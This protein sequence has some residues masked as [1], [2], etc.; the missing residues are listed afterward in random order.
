MPR[1]VKSRRPFPA[2]AVALAAIALAGCGGGGDS[3]GSASGPVL[4]S[5][6]GASVQVPAGVPAPAGSIK[7]GGSCT[8]AYSLTASPVLT[9]ADPLLAQQWH[10][11]NTGQRGGTAGEDLRALDAWATTRGAGVRV[12][13]IDDAV[14]VTHP[15]LRPN[16]VD[17]ASR[18]YRAGNANTTWPLPCGTDDEHGTAV[19]GL[20]LARDDNGSG[21]AG[22]APRA[23]LVAFD[24]LSSG[25]DADVA[26]A[27]TRDG[28]AN[29]IYQ[30][31]WGSPDNG[32]LSPADAPFVAALE[33]GVASGRGGL[34]SVYVFAGGNG[35]C[36]ARASAAGPCLSDDSNYDGYV[37]QRAVITVCA[38]DDAGR[39]PSYG[40]PGA[41]LTVCAPSSGVRQGITTTA[42]QAQTRDDFS[43]TSA[44]TPMVSGVAAL[45]LAANPQLTWRDVRLILAKSARKND[46]SDP[47]WLGPTGGMTFNH[48]YGFGVADAQAAVAMARTWT[49]VGGSSTL[50]RCGPYAGT[51][52]VALPDRVGTTVAERSDAV[53]V[54]GCAITRIE[55]VEVR[56]T[57]QHQYAGDLRVRLA[58]PAG[59]TSRL[60]DARACAGGCGS[61]ANWLF[62]SMRHLDEAPNGTWTL[63]VA[64]D[65]AQDTGTF[66][67]WSLV[68]HG[69]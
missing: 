64:D 17:G 35:G 47:D 65:A 36:Y 32:A 31:S 6:P 46:P 45:M 50:R 34:G 26:D 7:V 68:I 18:S 8:L 61:Y 29:W 51:P 58:S 19:A 54:A 40:E 3:N 66:Q 16:L 56:L 48:K 24:A 38:V 49:S 39:R 59:T 33:Q 5:T 62:G 69:S 22:V 42:L 41:N 2:L 14:E 13:V 4:P 60:A 63:R 55:F 52:N 20:V 15:D 67:S 57:A 10:L 43:G 30:N 12:A 28:T 11:R 44:S 23:S 27:L 9:G 25:L 53:A 1:T 21:T 37:N